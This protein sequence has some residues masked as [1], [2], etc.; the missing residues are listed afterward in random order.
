M[1]TPGTHSEPLADTIVIVGVG[2]LGGSIALASRERG[3]AKQIVGVGRSA[4][5]IEQAVAAGILDAGTTDLAE[6]AKQAD[7]VI[8][9]TPVDSIAQGV[10]AINPYLPE[11]CIV[12]D[13][14]ST[15]GEI[16]RQIDAELGKGKHR[17]IG[18]HPLAGSEKTGFEHSSSRLFEQ[19]AVVI[20]PQDET[21]KSCTDFLVQFWSAMGARIHLMSPESHDKTLAMTSHLPHLVASALAATIQKK[22]LPLAATGY[23]DTTRIAAGDPELWTSIFLQ[24]SS[25]TLQAIR[26]FQHQLEEMTEAIRQ[27]N[28][29]QLAS[30]LE[31]GKRLRDSWR[32]G[33]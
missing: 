32:K 33:E 28:S 16:C 24:N 13:V 7:L 10:I 8:F 18:A 12:S 17:F 21:T 22:D 23:A 5:R 9:C 11:N 1:N 2:L 29:R 3:L 14:G 15:K 25:A 4:Q 31:T 30:Q 20:T 26:E 27:R 19:A 6:A